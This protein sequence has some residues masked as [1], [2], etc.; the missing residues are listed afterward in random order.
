MGESIRSVARLFGRVMGV[1]R[2]RIR[3]AS[4]SN[5]EVARELEA[6]VGTGSSYTLIPR[7]V[8]EELGIR[9]VRKM[10][11]RLASGVRIVRDMGRAELSFD[12]LSTPTWIVFGDPDD[13]VLLG[14]V[15]LQKLGLEVDPTTETLRPTEI[16]ML[17]A[18]W[19]RPDPVTPAA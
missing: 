11:A 3:I 7:T 16:Y 4:P 9:P 2:V 14:A 15:T 17:R 13:A 10:A 1:F 8:A 6:V 19:R 18:A 12:T 5:P